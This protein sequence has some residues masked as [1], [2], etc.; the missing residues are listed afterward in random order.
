MFF[1]FSQFIW[2]YLF[3]DMEFANMMT[4][5]VLLQILC[6]LLTPLEK[7]VLID[8]C[9]FVTIEERE[10]IVHKII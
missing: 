4:T 3:Y 6:S 9:F 2:F 1:N 10:L 7:V 8:N 5:Y